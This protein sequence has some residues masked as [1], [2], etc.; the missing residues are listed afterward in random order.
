MG[1]NLERL[2]QFFEQQK[3]RQASHFPAVRFEKVLSFMGTTSRAGTHAAMAI[4]PILG[5]EPIAASKLNVRLRGPLPRLPGEGECITV[6]LT[7]VDQYQGYQVKSRPLL[8]GE[9]LSPLCEVRG[10]EIT[11]KGEHIFTV[12]HSPYAMTFF[13]QIPLEEVAQLVTGIRYALLAVGEQAN[14]SPRFIFHVERRDEKIALYHG[15]GLALKTYLNLR[16]NRQESRLV[17]DLDDFSGY[18]LRG[19]IAEFQPH[20]SPD[21][22]DH[23]CRGFAAGDWGKPSRVFKLVPDTFEEIAPTA[24]STKA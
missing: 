14:I 4:C 9:D 16:S 18:L 5:V 20:Q 8:A 6:H 1:A 2:H 7:N 23:I 22:Y 17:L 10:D 13:E 3:S 12:H 24:V 21:A 19:T 15:D 11:I